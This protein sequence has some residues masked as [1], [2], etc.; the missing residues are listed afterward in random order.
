MWKDAGV[1][2][3]TQRMESMQGLQSSCRSTRKSMMLDAQKANVPLAEQL[4]PAQESPE[5]IQKRDDMTPT[6]SVVK[7]PSKGTYQIGSMVIPTVKGFNSVQMKLANEPAEKKK[8]KKINS[9]GS[10][11]KE[12]PTI[13][14]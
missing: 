4:R 13:A 8:P 5:E 7:S 2:A 6:K 3:V 9:A 14:L 10:R 12:V 11:S 1:A